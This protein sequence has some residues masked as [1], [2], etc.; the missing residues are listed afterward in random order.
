MATKA[1]T[2]K[3]D[4]R[5]ATRVRATAKPADIAVAIEAAEHVAKRYARRAHS[6]WWMDI[7]DLR[8]VA[9]FAALDALRRHDPKRG[10][11]R[12]HTMKAAFFSVVEFI[13]KCGAPVSGPTRH[14]AVVLRG[15]E[16]A[17]VDDVVERADP[18]EPPDLAVEDDERRR[19]TRTAIER[20][21]S[22]IPNA[23]LAR[24]RLLDGEAGEV[25]AERVGVPL[26][27]VY[28]ATTEARKALREDLTL[29]ALYD[30]A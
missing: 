12:P 2:K 6:F 29:R 25:V 30:E 14:R 3:R 28:E 8:Q 22:R 19:R 7:D 9:V 24:A 17:P 11:V 26:W 16:R 15:L 20:V 13:R 21:L 1:K 27:R 23:D 5:C 18:H 4:R 10:P